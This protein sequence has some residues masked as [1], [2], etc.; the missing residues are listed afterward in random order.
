MAKLMKAKKEGRLLDEK[1]LKELKEM[2][3]S[4]IYYKRDIL[5]WFGISAYEFECYKKELGL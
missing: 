1:E 5:D 3:L 2:Y 4:G